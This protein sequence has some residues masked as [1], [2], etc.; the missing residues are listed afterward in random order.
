MKKKNIFLA[1]AI[2]SLTLTMSSCGDDFLERTPSNSYTA[3][4]FYSSD[5]AVLKAVEPL[6]NRAWFNFNRRALI[7]MGSYR[8]NDA[9]NPYVS[10]EF[11]RFQLT[12]LT[13]DLGLAWSAL[14]V[15]VSMSNSI[16]SDIP[17][18]AT[19]D[20]SQSVKD[21]AMGE[22]YLMRATAYFYLLR[23]WGDVIL[24]EDNV[25]A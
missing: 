12:G 16:L 17:A 24:Y 18:Y 1:S 11:A 23:G 5:D 7:G 22:A 21:L 14:Y 4:T 15:V 13:E 25:D 3:E 2:A 19:D 20:V 6:Y 8:A 10:A 9:W